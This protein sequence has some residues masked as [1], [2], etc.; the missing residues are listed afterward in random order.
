MGL[1]RDKCGSLYLVRYPLLAIAAGVLIV[2][3][4][5]GTDASSSGPSQAGAIDLDSGSQAPRTKAEGATG[6]PCDVD[7]I[8]GEN[9]RKCHSDPPQYG[10]PM[11]LLTWDDLQ[12]PAPS[13]P[14]KKVYEMVASKIGDDAAPM[15]PP[16]NPRLGPADRGVVESWI[17]AGAPKDPV[18]CG[19]TTTDPDPTGF[20]SCPITKTL[21]PAA[22]WEMPETTDDE[23]V[24]WGVDVTAD[25]PTHITGFAPRIDNTRIVHHVVMYEAPSSYPSTPQPCDSG[26]A[27]TWRMV[28][29]WAPGV[30]GIELPPVA[31]FP[32]AEAGTHYVVQM[33]Y[34][35]I[36]HLAGQKDTTKIDLCTSPPRP[37]EADV[38]AFGTQDITIPA[39]PPAGG[40][41]TRNCA[42]NV[43]SY[44]AGLHLFTAMPHMHQTGVSMSTTLTRKDG[45][46]VDLGTMPS[47]DF[48]RQAWVPIDDAVTQE[49]DVIR[50]KC[51]YTN[52]TGHEIK[53][54]E[55]TSD[56]MCYS[57]TMYYPRI[58]TP[59]WSWALPAATS[60]CV[61]EP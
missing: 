45:T 44:L 54:G 13:S 5:G 18:G 37:Y 30:K 60:Q 12:K 19:T 8:L 4:C 2:T 59:G 36:Q 1:G 41:F 27:I 58:K 21:A 14:D 35:N 10:A 43:P 52:R 9:C 53:F 26:A 25:T 61:S 55:K 38:A 7:T 34:S 6:L 15:P 28:L 24:C 11:A 42:V 56:E 22:A 20:L 50:T 33:H 46:T 32:I 31:G 29:G 48:S 17:A 40:V 49:G 39:A 16:P 23:Y 47:Y 51:G 3:A 57:F